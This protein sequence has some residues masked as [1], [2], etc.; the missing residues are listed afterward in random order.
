M[1]F[2]FRKTH[3]FLFNIVKVNYK[4]LLRDSKLVNFYSFF[5]TSFT[6]SLSTPYTFVSSA[7]SFV[8]DVKLL[9]KSFISMIEMRNKIC[10]TGS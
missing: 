5:F 2:V 3:Y 8:C 4:S 10:K 7:K 6:V 1:Y 9:A